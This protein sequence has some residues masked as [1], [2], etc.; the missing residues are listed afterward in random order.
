MTHDEQ[1]AKAEKEFMKALEKADVEAM[2]YWFGYR[3]GVL[4]AI[5]KEQSSKGVA[6]CRKDKNLSK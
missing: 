6:K 2:I 5:E 1:L 3:N 4:S